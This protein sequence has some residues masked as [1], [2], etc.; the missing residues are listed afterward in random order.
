[1]REKTRRCAKKQGEL[2]MDAGEDQT[3][4]ENE[5]VLM[6]LADGFFF[7]SQMIQTYVEHIERSKMQ[8]VAGNNQ[9]EGSLPGRR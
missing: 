6:C 9:T 1:M 3:K 2:E 5:S 4:A 8:Q 7:S